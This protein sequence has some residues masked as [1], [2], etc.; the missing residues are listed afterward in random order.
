M[1]VA[2]LFFGAV[3]AIAV[4]WLAQQGL[5][6]KPWLE[7]GPIDGVRGAVASPLPTAKV[8]LAVFLAVVGSLFALFI[9]AYS[10]RM[11]MGDWRYLPAPK[12]LWLNTGVLVLSSMALHRAQIAAGRGAVD[13]VRV[14]LLAGGVFTLAFLAGQL[15]AW[16][17]LTNAGYFLATNPANT[18]FYLL[19]AVHGLHLLGGMVALGRAV[20]KAW[21]GFEMEQ[22][23]LSVELCAMYWHFLLLV[24]LVL[25]GLLLHA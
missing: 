18:F 19:T 13:R 20:A 2:I 1:S 24:W 10:M 22:V 23:R 3:A 4:W 12:L 7:E 8:G 17:Q 5:T 6:T 15:L 9:L 14:G 21:R 25:F 11:R 16:R